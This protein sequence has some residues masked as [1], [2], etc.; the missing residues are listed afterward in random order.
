MVDLRALSIRRRLTG[1][2]RFR[3]H[4][5]MEIPGYLSGLL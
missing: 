3:F 5:P 4:F 1:A 2:K